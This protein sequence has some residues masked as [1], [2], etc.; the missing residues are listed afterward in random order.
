M[1]MG[2]IEN[3]RIFKLTILVSRDYWT[4]H[5][6]TY[7]VPTNVYIIY[8]DSDDI[9]MGNSLVVETPLNIIIIL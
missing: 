2:M 4:A 6:S 3:H 1:R 5:V 9:N 8:Y 7:D